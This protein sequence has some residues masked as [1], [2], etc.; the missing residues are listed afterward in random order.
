MNKADL[1]QLRSKIVADFAN[2]EETVSTT[3]AAIT[4]GMEIIPNYLQSEADAA[5]DGTD[6]ENAVSIFDHCTARQKELKNALVRMD[7]GE[8]GLC[9]GCGCEIGL[10]RLQ[11]I[12]GASNCIHCQEESEMRPVKMPRKSPF[13]GRI[14][15]GWVA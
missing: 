7:S 1:I 9:Q 5:K 11:V 8:F 13:I 12:P 14:L 3:R 10:A 4:E 15:S 6:I 2:L